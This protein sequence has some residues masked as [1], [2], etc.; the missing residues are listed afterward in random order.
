MR[1]D[2]NAKKY[3]K[4]TFSVISH[5]KLQLNLINL[6]K[7]GGDKEKSSLKNYLEYLKNCLLKLRH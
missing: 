7:G 1:I 6:T 3:S 2:I 4:K 5:L